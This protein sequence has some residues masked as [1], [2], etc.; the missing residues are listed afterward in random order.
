MN[1]EINIDAFFEKAVELE[2]AVAGF[3]VTLA[4]LNPQ[5][6]KFFEGLAAEEI[7]HADA[8]ASFADFVDIGTAETNPLSPSY[9][10]IEE[11]IRYVELENKKAINGSIDFEQALNVA[12]LI[13]NSQL[14][15]EYASHLVGQTDTVI[16]LIGRITEAEKEHLGRLQKLA[17][18]INSG[19][20]EN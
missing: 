2:R 6:A 12:L 19:S 1:Q 4:K 7:E 13:E 18:E 11:G 9:A 20:E 14:E 16:N 15:V 10:E 3:Y 8:L 17:D 5:H